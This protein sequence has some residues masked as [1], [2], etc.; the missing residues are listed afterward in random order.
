M[1]T[2]YQLV[3][4]ATV[5]GI[6]VYEKKFKSNAKGLCKGNKIGISS[7]I[8]TLTERTCILAEE[9]GHYHTTVGNI[10]D[11]SKAMNRKQERRAR[12]W[13]Y[14]RLIPLGKIIEA[15]KARIKDRHNV[16]DFLGVTDEFLQS[17]ID[18][19]MDKYGLFVQ[20]KDHIIFF[21][22]LIVIEPLRL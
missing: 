4:E 21:E 6:N 9:L 19:Y 15:H 12:E 17:T 8:A 16:A 11:Q 10:L 22:P 2:Y 20:F 1:E 3:R 18:R 7:S 14:N 5:H 13:A